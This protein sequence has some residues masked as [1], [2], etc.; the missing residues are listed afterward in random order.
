MME[1]KRDIDASRTG[2]NDSGEVPTGSTSLDKGAEGAKKIPQKSKFI[3]AVLELGRNWAVAVAVAAFG[4]AA[5]HDEAVMGLW[6]YKN[7]MLFTT[8]SFA[9]LWIAMA[10]YRFLDVVEI[11]V[12][13]MRQALSTMG[14]IT[15]L[16]LA[17]IGLVL[18]AASYADNRMFVKICSEY[19][20]VPSSAAHTD[21]RCQKLY[22]A[23]AAKERSYMGQ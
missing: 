9:V 19:R 7:W 10:V 11:S 20:E 2:K 1:E 17:G 23:R 22:S 16:V 12:G 5:Y 21:S 8:I 15:L 3:E 14:V 4:A 6:Q 13:G 18:Q